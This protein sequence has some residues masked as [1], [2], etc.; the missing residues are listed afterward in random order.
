VDYRHVFFSAQGRISP[1]T[2]GQGYIILTGLVVILSVLGLI[3]TPEF[4][5]LQIALF[6]PYLCVFGKR[7]H[8][9][10]QSAWL[11]LAILV[12]WMLMNGIATM[13]LMQAMTP[14]AYVMYTELAE[15]MISATAVNPEELQAKAQLVARLSAVPNLAGYLVSAAIVGFVAYSLRS[16]PRPNRHGPPTSGGGRSDSRP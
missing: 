13:V 4:S 6:F 1:R 2:F 11:W 9:A 14:Q 16:D 3:I 12:V 10:G 7:L 15:A 8:D 5:N